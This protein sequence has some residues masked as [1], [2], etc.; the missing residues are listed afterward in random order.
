MAEI[1]PGRLLGP[2]DATQRDQVRRLLAIVCLGGLTGALFLIVGGILT[3][4][5]RWWIGAVLLVG[6]ASW[7]AAF[8]RRT[9]DH[10]NIATVITQVVVVVSAALISLAILEP[11][12]ASVMA[13]AMLLPIAIALPYL[14]SGLLRRL[15]LLSSAAMLAAALAGFLPDA[16][17]GTSAV[18]MGLMR[19][20]G[21]LIVLGA[22]VFVMHQ[23]AVRLKAS[24]REFSRLFGLSADLAETS[25]PSV[26]GEITARHLAAAIGFDDCVL[27]A[28]EPETGR[29]VPFGS[30]PVERALETRPESVAERPVLQRVIRDRAH[31]LVDVADAQGDPDGQACLRRL[32]RS[33]MLVL[34]LVA[35]TGPVGVA[36]LTAIDRH[37]IDERRLALLRMLAFEA[38]MAIENGRLYQQIRER[39]LHDPL[40]GLA[41]MSLFHDRTE[42]ALE[43][44]ARREGALVA[45]LFVDLDDFKAI[46][47]RLGHAAGDRLLITVAER[48]RT[49]VRA[50]DTVA[51]LGGDEFGLLLEE[52][53]SAEEARL[54]AERAIAAVA[55]PLELAGQA[56]TASLSIGV[57]V[58]ASGGATATTV[59]ALIGE[60]DTAMYEAKRG[61]KRRAAMAEPSP[62]RHEGDRR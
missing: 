60:A 55:A 32:G 44:L 37:P 33:V 43:Q 21:L 18:V 5:V 20:G 6:A 24:G 10:T 53:S 56:V 35:P 62:V 23:S 39:S 45:V 12:F 42:H 22:V 59:D 38:A 8:P 54:I 48:L 34:P 27:Y 40:T 31:A 36:E 52:L 28:I 14:E 4:N 1:E 3:G 15:V 29:L 11:H 46:N 17:P 25:D 49:V 19:F 47:D 51:R 57:A 58:R 50:G 7:V 13:T 61:G 2:D 16:H 30:S 41:N 26:L 9:V